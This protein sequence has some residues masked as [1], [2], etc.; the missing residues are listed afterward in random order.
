MKKI[1]VYGGCCSRD[2]F[3][4]DNSYSVVGYIARTSIVSMFS[5]APK[6]AIDFSLV[7]SPFQKRMV[8]DD[9]NKTAKN[10]LFER[11]DD[12]VFLW[13]F[14]LNALICWKHPQVGY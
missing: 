4:F 2:A 13:I 6:E 11:I 12:G 8:E 3:N 5:S 7:S 14:W 9:V 10:I 1:M